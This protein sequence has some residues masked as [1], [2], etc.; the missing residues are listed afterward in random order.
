M[1]KHLF[2]VVLNGE[3]GLL[4]IRFFVW[5]LIGL[6]IQKGALVQYH[7][8]FIQQIQHDGWELTSVSDV[9]GAVREVD[10]VV[11]ITNHSQYDY[12]KLAQESR[13]VVDTR[14]AL[15]K[16]EGVKSKIYKL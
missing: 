12:Q 13:I 4:T 14:N 1:V 9:I 3:S 16:I 7:D 11:I 15:N 2:L 6:L 10:C 5:V 8:P